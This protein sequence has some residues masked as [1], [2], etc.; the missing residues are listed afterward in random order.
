MGLIIYIFS[1][2]GNIHGSLDPFNIPTAEMR[3]W[4]AL[5]ITAC[6]L[7]SFSPCFADERGT[8]LS[9]E[10]SKDDASLKEIEISVY[11]AREDAEGFA[12]KVKGSGFD[13]VVRVYQTANGGTVYGVFVLVHDELPKGPIKLDFTGNGGKDESSFPTSEEMQ[14]G[15]WKDLFSPKAGYFHVGLSV[16]EL[17]T[18]NAYNTKTDKKSDLSTVF[19]PVVWLTVPRLNQKPQGL[20]AISTRS[21]GGLA[22]SRGPEE[23]SRRYYTFLLYQPDIPLYSKNSP[24]GNTTTHNVQGGLGYKFPS[25]LSLEMNNEYSRSYEILNPALAPGQ[26]NRF[27]SNLFYTTA[28]FDTGNKFLFRFDYSNFILRYDAQSDQQLNRQDN[29]FSGYIFY[30]LWPKTSLFTQYSFTDIGYKTDTSLDNKQ[31]DVF[32]GVQW[33]MTAKSTGSIKAGWGST[34]FGD[35]VTGNFIFE[36]TVDHRLSAKN[37]LRLTAFR[38]IDETSI[39]ATFYTLVQGFDMKYSHM[40]TYM[41]TGSLD[42]SYSNEIY[43]G[44]LTFGGMTGQRKDNIYQ[45]SLGLQYE[46]RKWLKTGVLYVFTVLESN[47]PGFNYSSDTVLVTVTG[48]L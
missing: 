18:D 12:E 33:D 38:R 4:L 47:F 40:V 9:P 15:T 11:A 3:K 14:A 24:S 26:V 36:A 17:Y 21:P 13:T 30:K 31:Y 37:S 2:L 46:C 7:L 23:G 48:S 32:G 39:P 19:S 20:D 6:C 34:D 10:S 1:V 8:Q 41:V 44:A 35:F 42:V 28:S 43:G 5:F 25:G 45:A 22:L 29:F 27:K 16:S